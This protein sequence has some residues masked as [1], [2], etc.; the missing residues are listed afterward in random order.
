MDVTN[1][2]FRGALHLLQRILPGASFVAIDFEFTG[3]GHS[4]PS[5]L[6][7]PQSRYDAARADARDYP[8][9][10]FGIS[11]FHRVTSHIPNGNTANS[12]IHIKRQQQRHPQ[13]QPSNSSPPAQQQRPQKAAKTNSNSNSNSS[14][15]FLTTD[16]H[17][18]TFN[19]N[20][21]PRA[22]YF[23]YSQ[24]YPIIDRDFKLQGSSLHFLASHG[25]DFAKNFNSGI[26]WLRK[27][28]ELLLR[29]HV[30]E[31]YSSRRNPKNPIPLHEISKEDAAYID[32]YRK[33]LDLWIS[34]NDHPEAQTSNPPPK[35]GMLE[36]PRP[37]FLRRL[38]FDL[39]RNN[40]PRIACIVCNVRDGLRLRVALHASVQ[41]AEIHRARDL[42]MEIDQAVSKEVAARLIFDLIH[43]HNVTLVVH[44][45]LLD[46][47]KWVANFVTELPP[48]LS[49]FKSILGSMFRRVFDT[50]VAMDHLH[51]SDQDV[52][53][54]LPRDTYRRFELLHYVE[55]LRKIAYDR[56]LLSVIDIKTLIPKDKWYDTPID[57]HVPVTERV[58]HMILSEYDEDFEEEEEDVLGFSRYACDEHDDFK[59]EAGYD[60]LETGTLFALICALS[61][62]H[63]L[64]NFMNKIN[65]GSCGGFKYTNLTTDQD[66]NE[67]FD[68]CTIVVSG[69]LNNNE[70]HL[71]YQYHHPAAREHRNQTVLKI[72]LEGTNFDLVK[73]EF[74]IASRTQFIAMLKE[75]EDD[76]KEGKLPCSKSAETELERV[77]S[78]GIQNGFTVSRYS[79]EYW[80]G[81]GEL[82]SRLNGQ[83]GHDHNKRRK[84]G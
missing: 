35:I 26:S 58:E 18:T 28:E 8:P 53:K 3:I 47:T 50:K 72:L 52:A 15:P 1:D 65:I 9:L 81:T 36:Y 73:S 84:M 43:R 61:N 41:L 31:V 75:R 2:N 14:P 79:R 42:Q 34:K 46:L 77:I 71:H 48:R 23:P 32:L 82:N 78:N 17:T 64:Q 25:F 60:A 7:T 59:H 74:V 33:N 27:P 49:D 76:D 20:L 16:W 10:Q 56:K 44:N 13:Q 40:Y 80:A 30:T 24:R 29:Q 54:L 68:K 37:P 39:I 66:D 69:E 19:F 6:D 70:H 38:V 83:S 22:V 63:Q 4:R 51:S 55:A 21:H 62:E 12:S 11:V 57:E 45:G 67:W 5:Q